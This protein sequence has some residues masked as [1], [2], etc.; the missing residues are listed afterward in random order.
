MRCI[1]GASDS[2]RP[3]CM[4]AFDFVFSLVADLSV[5]LKRCYIFLRFS[6]YVVYAMWFCFCFRM[7]AHISLC[8]VIVGLKSSFRFSSLCV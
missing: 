7:H 1:V 6:L 5:M 4:L 8:S 3:T 2:F